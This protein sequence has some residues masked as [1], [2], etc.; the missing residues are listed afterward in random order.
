MINKLYADGGVMLKNPSP[1][2]G[3]WAW[4]GVGDDDRELARAWGY[5]TPEGARVPGVTNN[6]TE[7]LALIYGLAEVPAEFAG[8]VYSDSQVS[9]GR[10][11]EG[12]AW[13]NVPTWVHQEYQGL[14][15]RLVHWDKIRHVLLD[16][17]P[18]K[19]QLASG[20]GK[21]GHPVSI[22]NVYCDK[23]CG[24]AAEEYLA[25]NCAARSLL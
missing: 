10:I 4:I 11:F 3:T 14:R 20:V 23:L 24:E 2:G 13:H 18:T 8:I 1:I 7:L 6:L 17:H 5:V 12:W 16:G 15:K 22:Y 21:R 25:R 9:L 19:A